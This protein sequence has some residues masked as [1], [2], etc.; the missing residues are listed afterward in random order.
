LESS[1]LDGGVRAMPGAYTKLMSGADGSTL[2]RF[3]TQ[4]QSSGL[5]TMRDK[6]SELLACNE[7]QAW[8]EL[9]GEWESTRMH[10]EATVGRSTL[11]EDVANE[12]LERC[13]Q[14]AF[15][16]LSCNGEKAV[17]GATDPVELVWTRVR[18]IVLMRKA[19]NVNVAN[20][21]RTAA[22]HTVQHQI[23]QHL[24]TDGDTVVGT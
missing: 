21:M 2:M 13:L 9:I 5:L 11:Q 12:E 20:I 7:T 10:F 19:Q 23:C 15:A 3:H 4:G 24:Y 8:A 16:L 18:Q 14:Q 22:L 1:A 6:L 17:A